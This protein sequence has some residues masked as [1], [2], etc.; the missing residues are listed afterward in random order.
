MIVNFMLSITSI[1][2]FIRNKELANLFYLEICTS[3]K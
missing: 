1:D 2:L 3:K